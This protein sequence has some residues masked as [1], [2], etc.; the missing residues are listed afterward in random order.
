MTGI[1]SMIDSCEKFLETEVL[2]QF[3]SESKTV[4]GH[5]I[6][7]VLSTGTLDGNWSE[8]ASV[9]DEDEKFQIHEASIK[10]S[11]LKEGGP[12][13][14]MKLS[15]FAVLIDLCYIMSQR[16]KEISRKWILLQFE[17]LRLS[18]GLLHLPHEHLEFWPFLESRIER[19][20][21]GF[22]SKVE[23]G[24]TNLT[25]IKAPFSKLVFSLNKM[26]QDMRAQSRLLTPAHFQLMAKIHSFL[27]QCLS[28]AEPAN[29]NRKGD[30]ARSLPLEIWD[31][32]VTSPQHF[33]DFHSSWTRIQE[34]FIRKPLN[35]VYGDSSFR[36][37]FE[38]DITLII[39][40]VLKTELR[41]YSTVKHRGACSRAPVARLNEVTSQSINMTRSSKPADSLC[42]RD[43]D[44]TSL[45]EI[46]ETYFKMRLS[47]QPLP[48]DWP[49][50]SPAKIHFLIRN[51]RI[52][53]YRKSFLE[54]MLITAD[55]INAILTDSLTYKFYRSQVESTEKH[56]DYD[57]DDDAKV[58][59]SNFVVKLVRNR[60]LE[61]YKIWDPTFFILMEALLKGEAKSRNLK[62]T[63]GSKMFGDFKYLTEDIIF[64]PASNCSSFKKFGWIR[65]GNKKID[66]AWNLRT[67]LDQLPVVPETP[68]ECYDQFQKEFKESN[69]KQDNAE[70]DEAIVQHWRQLRFLRERYLFELS[71]VDE[72]TGPGGLFDVSLIAASKKRKYL[73]R[74]VLQQEKLHQHA[75]MLKQAREFVYHKRKNEVA[76]ESEE[77]AAT[78]VQC[79]GSSEFRNLT[80]ADEL[81]DTL[82]STQNAHRSLSASKNPLSTF[83]TEPKSVDASPRD[84]TAQTTMTVD[85]AAQEGTS[86]SPHPPE[87]TAQENASTQRPTVLEQDDTSRPDISQVAA[88]ESPKISGNSDSPVDEKTLE[89]SE[90]N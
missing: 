82:S 62:I 34:H 68:Q 56:A 41:F 29:A 2:G 33:K 89:I 65:L 63:K 84:E 72:E 18:M 8:E 31:L 40:D 13:Q 90:S 10:K 45:E 83:Q 12:N 25:A 69:Q 22:S 20:K 77:N 17:L 87:V 59:L 21:A 23:Y 4:H 28:P 73:R 37:N 67:G 51:D 15:R 35:W 43:A 7:E 78:K 47:L 14:E 79:V 42:S 9:L 36:A 74:Q 49:S 75:E 60:I 26:L 55:L 58:Q 61:F 5:D 81:N 44:A 39:D 71:K 53:N 6:P 30:I 70:P 11:F 85:G 76:D 50:W 80:N 1:S 38:K 48:L 32:N 16:E 46:N 52:D 3:S 27:A 24:S 54:Q 57:L 66:S 19:L 64:V 88:K 86:A